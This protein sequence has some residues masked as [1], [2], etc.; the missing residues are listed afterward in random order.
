[1]L[2]SVLHKRQCG[3]EDMRLSQSQTLWGFS[4]HQG[5]WR[6]L[7]SSSML[8]YPHVWRVSS[9]DTFLTALLGELNE[10]RLL[11]QWAQCLLKGKCSLGITCDVDDDNDDGDDDGGDDAGLWKIQRYSP[12]SQDI[13]RPVGDIDMP[14]YSHVWERYKQQG[15]QVGW[16]KAFLPRVTREAFTQVL[17]S[18]LGPQNTQALET[19]GQ[20]TAPMLKQN[21]TWQ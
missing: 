7:P 6:K 16:L 5:I 3:T 10:I 14:W 9:N 15:Q 18:K 20:T 8:P 13:H 4:L 11:R 1:M 2:G 12:F 19:G 21:Q 17:I